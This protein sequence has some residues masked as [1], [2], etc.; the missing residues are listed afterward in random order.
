MTALAE[1][2]PLEPTAHPS[3]LR[4]TAD[5]RITLVVAAFEQLLPTRGNHRLQS[6][7]YLCPPRARSSVCRQIAS[8]KTSRLDHFRPAMQAWDAHSLAAPPKITQTRR[9]Q[10]QNALSAKG[11][12]NPLGKAR[13]CRRRFIGNRVADNA[14]A[15]DPESLRDR[16]QRARST[17]GTR[18]RS[19][20]PSG[21]AAS[22]GS[23]PV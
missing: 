7:G 16:G 14:P 22:R 17:R 18:R 13:R 23:P 3:S 10:R 9:R 5:V 21:T 6:P 8:G 12:V 4:G 15:L 20:N 11:C 1:E 19:S 2:E